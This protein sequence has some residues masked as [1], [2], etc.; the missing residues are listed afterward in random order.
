[1]QE[2]R[3]WNTIIGTPWF[4]APENLLDM[5]Y[6]GGID[7]WALGCVFEFMLTGSFIFNFKTNNKVKENEN[8]KMNLKAIFDKLGIPDQQQWPEV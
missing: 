8:K 1:L 7:V 5:E 6:S 3:G 2:S 4:K